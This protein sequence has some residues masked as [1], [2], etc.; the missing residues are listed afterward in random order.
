M[1]PQKSEVCIDA[2]LFLLLVFRRVCPAMLAMV[3]HLPAHAAIYDDVL[4]GDERGLVA[5]QK[6]SEIRDVIDGSDTAKRLLF[7][8]RLAPFL[9]VAVDPA[10]RDRVDANGRRQGHRHGVRERRQSA[11]GRGVAFR[12]RHRL[13]LSGGGDV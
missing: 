7:L 1:I 12:L 5:C 9:R 4:R 3:N 8:V 13:I 6:Q 10:R 2:S 11:F